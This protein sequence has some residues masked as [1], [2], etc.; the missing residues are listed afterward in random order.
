MSHVG[1]AQHPAVHSNILCSPGSLQELKFLRMLKSGTEF[2]FSNEARQ[3]YE[4][5]EKEKC[6][7]G[8]V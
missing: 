5:T 1:D 8:L 4:G 6:F 2:W 3:V 7:S